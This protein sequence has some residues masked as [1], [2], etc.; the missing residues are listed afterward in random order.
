VRKKRVAFT[1]V[2]LL[3]VLTII[4]MLF[5]LMMPTD[6]QSSREHPRQIKCQNNLKQ[7][8]LAL[9]SYANKHGA[10]PPA[11]TTDADGKPL[12][13]W[14]T[15]ILP[16]LD[17]AELFKKIDLTK[18]WDDPANAEAAKTPIPIFECPSSAAERPRTTYFAVVT[19]SSWLQANALRRLADIPDKSKAIL[20]IE[21][22][23][24]HSAPWM[25]PVDADEDLV[26]VGAQPS[27]Q[28]HPGL[29]HA[30]FADGRVEA[31]SSETPQEELRAMIGA[32]SKSQAEDAKGQ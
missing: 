14:R 2:E 28:A 21:V 10:L 11:C 31:I 16:E 9:L 25:Q 23:Y 19:P 4:G 12:H 32:P 22:D 7:I 30:L 27:R 17:Q 26:L 5:A 3:V 8:G 1:L 13:S 24:D 15:L 20:V 6:C 29:F 18:S